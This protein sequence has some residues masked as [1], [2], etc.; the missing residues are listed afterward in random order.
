MSKLITPSPVGRDYIMVGTVPWQKLR[1]THAHP[2][3][4]AW[5][6]ETMVPFRGHMLYDREFQERTEH[7]AQEYID[8]IAPAFESLSGDTD[9]WMVQ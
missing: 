7:A 5:I 3:D 2:A 4:A 1:T 6:R 8:A 9:Q